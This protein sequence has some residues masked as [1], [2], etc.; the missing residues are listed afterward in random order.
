MHFCIQILR[1]LYACWLDASHTDCYMAI[2]LDS[3]FP[4]QQSQL[5]TSNSR[6]LHRRAPSIFLIYTVYAASYGRQKGEVV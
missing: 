5:N 4:I 3:T 6:H 2:S 1:F